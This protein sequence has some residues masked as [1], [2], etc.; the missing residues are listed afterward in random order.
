M[1]AVKQSPSRA[2]LPT[3]A[4][5]HSYGHTASVAATLPTPVTHPRSPSHQY[6]CHAGACNRRLLK[7]CVLAELRAR[8]DVLQALLEE[9]WRQ[10]EV[11]EIT[12]ED[13]AMRVHKCADVAVRACRPVTVGSRRGRP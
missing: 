5:V 2:L 11:A 7:N 3:H 1:P 12:Q 10:E 13:R 4:H 6:R 9:Q 8:D